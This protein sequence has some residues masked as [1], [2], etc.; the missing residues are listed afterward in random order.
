[1][2]VSGSQRKGSN[3][4]S[5]R[6]LASDEEKLIFLSW[7]NDFSFLQYFDTVGWVTGMASGW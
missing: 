5:I 1:M 4:S 7:F 6:S 3:S 2:L